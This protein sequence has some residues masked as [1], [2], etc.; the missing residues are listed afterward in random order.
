MALSGVDRWK[1]ALAP[2]NE[3]E[4]VRGLT[5]AS[6]SAFLISTSHSRVLVVSVSS[7][8]G[9]ISINVR[10]LDRALG[11]AGSVWSAVFGG[12]AADPKAGILALTVS[13][14]GRNG[15]KL[16]YAVT[17]KN[18]QVWRI[19]GLDD[20]VERLAVEQDL[21]AGVLEGLKGGTVG[22]EEWAINEGKVEIVEVKVTP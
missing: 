1:S 9:R 2:L 3:G 16:A 20:G 11:W 10:V 22:N 19:P 18:V 21:F 15:E 7:G 8:G 14:P 17:D 4:L 5:M 12:K 6:P 13:A